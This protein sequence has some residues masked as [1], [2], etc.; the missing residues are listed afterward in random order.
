VQVTFSIDGQFA[1]PSTGEV[2]DTRSKRTAATLSD[3]IGRAVQ[4]EKL[5]KVDFSDRRA[6]RIGDQFGMGKQAFAPHPLKVRQ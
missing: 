6:T 2:I 4:C 3:E 1:I 5:R